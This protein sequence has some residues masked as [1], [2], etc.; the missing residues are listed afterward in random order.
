MLANHNSANDVV[1]TREFVTM[2]FRINRKVIESFR[3]QSEESGISMNA[4]VNQVLR[5]YIEWDSFEPRVGMIPFPKTV[6]A[7]IFA[8][9][10]SDQIARL[11]SSV[12]KET[13]IDM[14]I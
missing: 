14:A 10:D 13:A 9:L 11:A 5:H 7:K 12:G 6:L 4:L 2:T 8:E 3:K 1:D